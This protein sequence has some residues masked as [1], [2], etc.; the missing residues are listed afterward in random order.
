[1]PIYN[2]LYCRN[3]VEPVLAAHECGASYMAAHYGQQS[4]TIGV[5]VATTGP[6]AT[7]M[8]T[9]VATAHA[10][11]LP[12]LAVT[13]QCH[14]DTVGMRAYQESTGFGRT[15]DTVELYKPVTKASGMMQSGVHLARTLSSWI[16]LAR[17]G[18]PGPVHIAV[19]INVWGQDIPDSEAMR[20][21]SLA[22]LPPR[23]PWPSS[24]EI[25]NLMA[26]I[27]RSRQPL[28]L[29]GRGVANAR[30]GGMAHHLAER[31]G[32]PIITTTRGRGAISSNSALNLGQVGMTSNPH[33][34]GWL[35]D[36][37]VDLVIAVGTSLSPASLG[38]AFPPA[39]RQTMSLVAVNLDETECRSAWLPETVIHS[40]AAEFFSAMLEQPA[41]PL[42]LPRKPPE[43]P[44]RHEVTDKAEPRAGRL[45]PLQVI[46]AINDL[47]PEGS[48]IIPDAG[49]HWVWCMRYLFSAVPH[50]ILTGRALGGMGQAIAGTVGAALA[51]PTRR[52]VCI[53]GDGC[54][55]MHG[56]ELTAAA[57]HAPNAVF[58]V[59]NDQSLN[60]VYHAQKTDFGGKVISSTYPDYGFG[61]IGAALGVKSV[62]VT[63]PDDFGRAYRSAIQGD[64]CALIECMI[65]QD[66]GLPK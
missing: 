40:D 57:R 42:T 1:M 14:Q 41:L 50:S 64:Q 66:A 53:T 31:L 12:L 65:D 2:E 16:P 6:G 34:L 3:D 30:A 20:L 49:S 29:L 4:Q 60:R 63:T 43:L 56:L 39:M 5:C 55:L 15:V 58:I 27:A 46:R 38:P 32:V 36:A 13:G 24:A 62:R 10:E 44:S 21:L 59:F 22:I 18:R 19:P 23:L 51:R 45:H 47:T 48:L 7:N 17:S 54:F 35:A 52:V 26:R 37:G 11:G 33:T 28:L 8:L 9:G 25:S 61:A